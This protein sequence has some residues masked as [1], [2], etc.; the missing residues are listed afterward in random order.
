MNGERWLRAVIIGLNTLG[1]VGFLG[2]L[3]FSHERILYTQEG[4]LYF[5]P[6]LPFF[7]IYFFIFRHPPP[8]EDT[9]ED[10]S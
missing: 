7:F 4:V 2:W 8:E 10:S 1:L 3:I 9:E 6:C 5:L